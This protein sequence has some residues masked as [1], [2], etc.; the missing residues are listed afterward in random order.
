MQMKLL[1]QQPSLLAKA[2]SSV[3]ISSWNVPSSPEI[4]LEYITSLHHLG[5]LLNNCDYDNLQIQ[6]IS[7]IVL[8]GDDERIKQCCGDV[9]SNCCPKGL[10]YF[11]MLFTARKF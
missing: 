10:L 1:K 3:S 6:W 9:W 11:L 8:S 5:Y 4:T 7:N 2:I